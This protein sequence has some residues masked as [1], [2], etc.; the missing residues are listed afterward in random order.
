MAPSFARFIEDG[1]EAL[2]VESI[3]ARGS[4]TLDDFI[5]FVHVIKCPAKAGS[6]WHFAALACINQY[7]AVAPTS[8]NLRSNKVRE[9]GPKH[10]VAGQC[11]DAFVRRWFHEQMEEVR[12]SQHHATLM[13]RHV[14]HI[15]A[16]ALRI[17]GSR[18]SERV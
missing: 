17:V 12:S 3:L 6:C 7:Q 2:D 13:Q 14:V 16:G 18:A 10:S 8:D 11:W 5:D 4:K 1:E 15:V 9:D